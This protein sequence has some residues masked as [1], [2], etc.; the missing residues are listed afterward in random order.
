MASKDKVWIAKATRKAVDSYPGG[1]CFSLPGGR[2][3]LVNKKMNELIYSLTGHTVIESDTVWDELARDEIQAGCQ[4]LKDVE[5]LREAGSGDDR[6]DLFFA[7]EN[8]EVWQ[9]HRQSISGGTAVQTT[10]TDITEQYHMSEKLYRN[11]VR[12]IEMHE[13]QRRLLQDI[14]QINQKREL[15]EAKMRIHD[16]LGQ[17][18]LGISRVLEEGA[19]PQ[20]ADELRSSCKAALDSLHQTEQ[21]AEPA[22]EAELLQVAR[23]IGCEIRFQG[24]RPAGVNTSRLFYAAVREAVMNAVSHAQ[25]SELYVE[26]E[27]REAEY[28]VRLWDNGT[29]KC[30][31][32]R[33]GVGLQGL[34][35]CL[36][37]DGGSMQVVCDGGVTLLVDLPKERKRK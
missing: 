23:M 24:P 22:M 20:E 33:E 11:N 27:E 30:H 14:V 17:C 9:F 19:T 35:H 7:L 10:A 4:N 16:E 18:L 37:Q 5:W 29:K 25:A 6:E 34:R 1:L 32:L 3:I 13:R 15:V 12:L 8:G 26:T 2:P 21:G 31:Q 28:H 36:E